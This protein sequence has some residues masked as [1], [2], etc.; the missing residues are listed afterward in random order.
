MFNNYHTSSD[1]ASGGII[2]PEILSFNDLVNT[3]LIPIV[4]VL[5]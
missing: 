5:G 1:R 2:S 4:R 3:F